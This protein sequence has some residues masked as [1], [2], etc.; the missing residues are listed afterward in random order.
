MNVKLDPDFGY[1]HWWFSFPSS[2]QFGCCHTSILIKNGPMACAV[3]VKM[4]YLLTVA[5]PIPNGLQMIPNC[6][7]FWGELGGE[8]FIIK[9]SEDNLHYL[10]FQFC[11]LSESFLLPQ[12]FKSQG[13][14]GNCTAQGFGKSTPAPPT[15]PALKLV[16]PSTCNIGET[17]SFIEWLPLFLEASPT[18]HEVTFRT[19]SPGLLHSGGHSRGSP[20]SR[21]GH[22][23][24][25]REPPHTWSKKMQVSS[26]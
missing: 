11:S 16:W 20:L 1:S 5:I 8:H 21:C 22:K 7:V 24:Q 14:Q 23:G 10:K 15:R 26:L 3:L 19:C 13:I 18:R 25:A 2:L 6:K 9:T 17:F 4:G 12:K